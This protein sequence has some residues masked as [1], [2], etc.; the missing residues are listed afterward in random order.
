MTPGSRTD[1]ALWGLEK[2]SLRRGRAGIDITDSSWHTLAREVGGR[3]EV[4][5]PF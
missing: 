4:A 3:G 5:G 1:P 2:R